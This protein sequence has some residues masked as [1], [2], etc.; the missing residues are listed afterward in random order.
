LISSKVRYSEFTEDHAWC[1]TFSSASALT[2]QRTF[3]FN[4]EDWSWR[5]IV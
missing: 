4:Y 5:E 1:S 3:C 2:S